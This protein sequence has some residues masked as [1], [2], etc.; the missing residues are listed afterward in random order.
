MTKVSR[1]P[2][3]RRILELL[4]DLLVR[5]GLRVDAVEQRLGWEPGR[6]A[7]LLESRRGMAIDD[8][9]E[10][11]PALDLQ[12]AD[13]FARLYGLKVEPPPPVEKAAAS[14]LDRRFE[15]SRRVVEDA[16]TRRTVWKRDREQ[17]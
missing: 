2:E 4:R 6:L 14:R 3:E 13:F 17:P 15:E 11:L 7:D 9:M 10:V 12:P 8:L 5:A 16:L 1:H